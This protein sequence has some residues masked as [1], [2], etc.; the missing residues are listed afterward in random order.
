MKSKLLPGVIAALFAAS[1][2]L[3]FEPFV[4][5]DIRVEG[6]QRTE[7]GTVFSYLPVKVGERFSEDKAS[8]AIKSL[9]A[10][11]FFKDVRIEVENDVIIVLVDERPAISQIDFVGIKEFEKDALKKGLKEVGLAESRIFDRALLERAEQELKRQ[12]LSKGLYGVQITTTVTPLER[13]RVGVNF[14]VVEGEAAKIRQ[15]SIIGNK[16]FKEKELVD[17]FSLTTP[18]WMTWYSKSDQYSK[19]K[20][21]A[22]IEALR[23]FYLNRGYLDFSIDSTQ[24]S[25]TPDKKD[26]YITL[27]ITEGEKYTVS[28]V[29]LAGNMVLPEADLQ[30]LVKLKPGDT[31]VRDDVNATTKAISDRLGNEGYAFANVNAAPEVD[32]VKREVAFTFFVDPGRRVYVRK[33]NFAGNAKTR[34]EVLRREVR[35]MEGAWYDGAALNR[36]KV[37]L[38]RLGYFEEVTIETPAVAGVTDQVDANFTVKE[39]ATGNLMLGA[40][41]SSAEKVI[42]SASI[43]QQNLFG[44]GNAMSLQMNTG[45]INRTI[46]LSFTN[47]YWTVDGISMGWDI[48]Q[49]NVDP[50]SLSVATYKSSSIGA[51]L[52]FGYP[53]A[54]DDRI[55]FGLAVDQ[56]TI[57]VYD[58]SPAPYVNFVNTFGDTARSLVATVGW[59]RDKRD[60]FLYPT[61]GVYQRASVEVATP[62]LDMRYVRGSYQHQYWIPFGGGYALMLNGD[63]GYA[64][65]YDGKEL[66]FYKNFYA[67]G[68]G[69][70]RGYQQSTLGPHYTDS[71]GYVRA[72]GGNRRA[73]ANAEYYFPM[74][75]QGKEK[76]MRLSFFAD[77][78]YVWGADDKVQA[79]DLRY[80]AGLAFTW[81][82]PVGPLKFSLGQALK[83]KDGDKTQKFQFQLGTVF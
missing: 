80:S 78:G 22:D 77:T 73:I 16:V 41:F 25:I 68:I 28:D 40:G 60:S 65:G 29:K 47:P 11:G 31:F 38:D 18:G 75:G 36:S 62:A 63:L 21:S 72:L 37:R 74:P 32:K 82:S 67:G 30:K 3:A 79:S 42:L 43:A 26:I 7:A 12:Y 17:L 76:S 10:T 55:N 39:R 13:N 53:I 69:S 83:K 61:S 1:P 19:Q 48:Y 71:S 27:S 34:D 6:I 33:I 24:V 8:Q 81:S 2:A 58:T 57:K 54:E 9:F 45:K 14:N 44:T 20:L 66:P 59:G 15:I 35:Q 64:H 46:A 49:R 5:K 4:V 51:G 56:T 23:S 52:R 50:T 70:V